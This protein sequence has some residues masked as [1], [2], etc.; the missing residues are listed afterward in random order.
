MSDQPPLPPSYP[1]AGHGPQHGGYP[2]T[3]T[4]PPVQPGRPQYPLPGAYPAA[5]HPQPTQ[6]F[7]VVGP[8]KKRHP[9]L[10]ILGGVGALVVLC[11][12]GTL[13]A[14]A[15]ADPQPAAND[16][17]VAESPDARPSQ[18][19]STAPA[20]APVPTTARPKPPP[21]PAGPGLGDKAR[22]GKFEFV[23]HSVK[24]G[25][26]RVGSELI[27][28]EAQGV[29]CMISVTVTNVGDEP[30]SF[31]GGNQRA[32]TADG[33]EFTNDT[34]AEIYA[35]DNAATFLNEINPGNRVRG[36]L[37]FDVP[38]GTRLARLELHDSLFSGGVSVRLA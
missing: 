8:P 5:G 1:P 29:Y 7:P 27:G 6:Q 24:C 19:T 33:K 20:P 18:P 17:V 21:K 34:E 16:A 35:N 25:K 36:T 15:L 31:T 14:G 11:C 30:R 10:W 9:L 13:I 2:A 22:D 23:V 12:G 26:T 37:V 4:G 28:A 3:P 32:F 38:K